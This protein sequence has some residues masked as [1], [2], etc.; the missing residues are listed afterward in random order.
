MRTKKILTMFR[1][2][3]VGIPVPVKALVIFTV[4]TVCGLF[5][6]VGLWAETI[7][8]SKPYVAS[9][10]SSENALGLEDEIRVTVINAGQLLD[11]SD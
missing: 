8:T 6:S 7:D 11:R 10:H 5:F 3:G 1:R 9:V 4:C 2:A